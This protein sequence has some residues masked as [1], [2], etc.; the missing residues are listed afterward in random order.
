MATTK[1]TVIE[2]GFKVTTDSAVSFRLANLS[3]Y[4]KLSGLCLK[5]MDIGWWDGS[6]ARLV[7]LELKGSEV[8]D[9]FDASKEE[10][11]NHLVETL[12]AKATDVLMLLAAV[13]LGTT[14]GSELKRLLPKEVGRYPGDGKIKLV[15]LVDTPPSRRPL[16]TAIK[17][18]L[19]KRSAGRSRLFGVQHLTVVD[20]DV[21]AKMDLPVTRAG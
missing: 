14:R 21:A 20:L 13:W 4:R 12:R 2:S 6:A 9:F 19:N 5:E 10:A 8:W 1:R 11:H 3:P 7:L 17:D 18:D 16:L 15:F